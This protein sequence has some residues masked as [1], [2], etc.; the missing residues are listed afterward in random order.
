MA[1]A[2]EVVAE[3]ARRELL[4]LLIRGPQAV[5]TLVAAT[6]LS[7]P[8]TSRHLRILREAG[9]VE[10]RADGRRRVYALRGEG[11]AE[12]ARWLTP[13]AL[14]WQGGL[15]ALERHLERRD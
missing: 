14:L 5:G 8:N 11:F 12:L 2:F 3:P 13:Y 10:A 9:L 15:D 6:G 7:Q 4:D 1:S